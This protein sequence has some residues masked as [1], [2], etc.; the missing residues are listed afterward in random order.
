[1]ASSRHD[2]HCHP[3]CRRPLPRLGGGGSLSIH[4]LAEAYSATGAAWQRG[5]GRVYD[6]LAAALVAATPVP[7]EGRTVLD[8]GAGAGAGTRAIW[9]A[10]GT[11]VALDVA[12]GMLQAIGPT[13]P[14]CVVADASALP[15]ADRCVDGVVAAF[16]LN[17]L[18]APSGALCEAVRAA[19]PGSPV[20]VSAYASEDGHPVKD[21]VDAAAAELGW[22]PAPWVS[23]LRTTSIPVLA[24][25]EGARRA[26]LDAGLVDVEVTRVDVGFPDLGP[27][28]LVAWRCGMAQVAPFVARLSPVE[29][30]RLR[31][32]A[33]D[34][35]GAAPTLVRRIVV[36]AAVT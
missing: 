34:L 1:M 14:A 18:P 23:D 8:V 24:S 20:L 28:D 16:S 22:K 33:I 3:Q 26:A 11:P 12:L 6:R 19:R 9:A 31:A 29:R 21:A 7:L 27:E 13:R 4:D 35:L 30:D 17:H 5:P 25:I 32:R 10:G 36:I 2:H 15:V